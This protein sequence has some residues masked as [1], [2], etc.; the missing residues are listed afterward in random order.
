MWVSG[1]WYSLAKAKVNDVYHIP[2]LAGS[3]EKVLWLDIAV[4]EG[5]SMEVCRQHHSLLFQFCV[6]SDIC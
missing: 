2:K 6:R 5:L 4:D 1:S 3:H